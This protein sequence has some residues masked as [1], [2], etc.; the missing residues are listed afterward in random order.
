VYEPYPRGQPSSP[1]RSP[2]PPLRA[3]VK[4]KCIL[5][6]V[7]IHISPPFVPGNYI[8]IYIYIYIYV[9][10]YVYSRTV[11]I[12]WSM[13]LVSITEV[14]QH[15]RQRVHLTPHPAPPPSPSLKERAQRW[16]HGGHGGFGP[17]STINALSPPPL[18]SEHGTALKGS[19]TFTWKPTP[20][21]GLDC[22]I[23][24][25]FARQ[26]EWST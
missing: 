11:M 16:R 4:Q 18:P 24:A 25:E 7:K 26:W 15:L 1:I 5:I 20:E 3:P 14:C 23:C 19:R 21:P 2:G 10:M 6:P 17:E 12:G 13:H 9:C 8:Y 22:L